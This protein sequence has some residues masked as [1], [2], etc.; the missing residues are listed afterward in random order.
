MPAGDGQANLLAS[1]PLAQLQ[2]IEGN[3]GGSI[4]AGAASHY[5]HGQGI[6]GP[7]ELI[8]PTRRGCGGVKNRQKGRDSFDVQ[9]HTSFMDPDDPAYGFH[10]E[11]EPWP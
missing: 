4:L 3:D 2:T 1:F 10:S 7:Q 6:I 8:V 5:S 9:F 11:L